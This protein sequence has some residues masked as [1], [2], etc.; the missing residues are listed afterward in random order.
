LLDFLP[1]P[2]LVTSATGRILRV[3]RAAV[4][5]LDVAGPLVNQNLAD[6]IGCRRVDVVSAVLRHE[7]TVVKLCALQNRNC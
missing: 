4:M 6:V 7:R 5:F 3:N 1:T 2:L